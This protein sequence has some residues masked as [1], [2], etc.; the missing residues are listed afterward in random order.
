MAVSMA[1]LMTAIAMLISVSIMINSFRQTV[2][3]WIDQSISGDLLVGPVFPSNQ[4]DFQF[5]EPEVIQGIETLSGIKDIYYYRGLLTASQGQ[6]VRLWSGNLAVIQRYSR[7]AFTAGN[8]EEIYRQVLTREAVILSEVLAN[9]LKVR[10]GDSIT[11]L[12]ALGPHSFRVAGVF[13]DYRTEGGGVWIDRAV[14]LKWWQDE[15]I[16]GVRLYLKEPGRLS[17]VRES[18]LKQFSDRY[19]LAVISHRELREQILRI[20]DQTFQ[21]TY[22]LEAIAILVAFLGIIHTSSILILFREKELGILKALGALPGQIRMMILT[23]TGLMGFF[24]FFWGGWAGTL[25]SL[26][27][28]LVINKQSFGWTI[29]LHWSFGVYGQTLILIL[30]S[31]ILAGLVPAAIA[32]RTKM[33]QQ[34]REE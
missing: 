21:V 2:D 29:Q 3:Q 32:L 26:I 15:R 13:Y 6:P 18:L 22:A 1:A 34:I 8:P 30:I 19:D 27:L 17:Q 23:E 4:G 10:S 33:E 11:L 25:L 12:T 28:I 31:S 7:L 16:N 14:F 9:R 5:L 20:F 24:S